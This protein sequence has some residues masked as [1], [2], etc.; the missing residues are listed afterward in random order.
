MYRC[1]A[2]I[3]T[4]RKVLRLRVYENRVL[5]KIFGPMRDEVTGEWTRMHNEELND[6]Y[7]SSNI[8][9]VM[10]SIKMRWAGCAA[11]SGNGRGAY[12]IVVGRPKRRSH[13]EDLD[14]DGR[15]IVKCIYKNLEGKG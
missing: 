9:L 8:I 10:K 1:E 15:I 12:K 7:S 3:V 5:R 6:L 4:L 13:L 14:E 11:C 2:W